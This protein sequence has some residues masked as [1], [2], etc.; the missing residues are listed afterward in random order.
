[1]LFDRSLGELH[2]FGTNM[3]Q[4]PT[5]QQYVLRI[6]SGD[7]AAVIPI[8]IDTNG[9]GTATISNVSAEQIAEAAIEMQPIVGD[10]DAALG[11]VS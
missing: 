9:V 3:S 11:P 6:G 7:K 2:F 5:G 1:M 10:A 8:K 4:P